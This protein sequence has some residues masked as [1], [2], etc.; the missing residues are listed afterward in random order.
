MEVSTGQRF[1]RMSSACYCMREAPEF[2]KPP[3]QG[4]S[5]T[6]KFIERL[7]G[8]LHRGLQLLHLGSL[9]GSAGLIKATCLK[10]NERG[11]CSWISELLACQQ[12]LKL[13]EAQAVFAEVWLQPLRRF[14]ARRVAQTLCRAPDRDS[15]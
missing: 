8:R 1:L 4:S 5:F 6:Q 13:S 11:G 10:T 2:C 15:L 7:L 3:N 14:F 9:K 12:R